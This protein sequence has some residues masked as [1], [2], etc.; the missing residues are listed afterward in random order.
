MD[1]TPAPWLPWHHPEPCL[2]RACC[3][4]VCDWGA[5]QA[6][7]SSKETLISSTQSGNTEGVYV[8]V[9]VWVNENRAGVMCEFF[10]SVCAR[11]ACVCFAA[12][13]ASVSRCSHLHQSAKKALKAL[14]YIVYIPIGAWTWWASGAA[15]VSGE[16]GKQM[17][18]VP[19]TQMFSKFGSWGL[20][21]SM[22]YTL[23]QAL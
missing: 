22:P 5:P 6:R 9:S 12:L 15:V 17:F 7:E 2:H 20:W 4:W 8:C 13:S 18:L 21:R 1:W 23:S 11:E 3:L 16:H 10:S 19:P 14:S